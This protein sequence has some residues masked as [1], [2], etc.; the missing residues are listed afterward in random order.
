LP[1]LRCLISTYK[2]NIIMKKQ[3]LT[4]KALALL[5]AAAIFLSSCASTTLIQSVPSGAKVYIDGETVGTTPHPHTDKK[6]I[7][8]NTSIVLEKEGYEPFAT[9]ITRSEEP[10]LGAIIGGI[11]IWPIWL[12]ALDY[13][14]MRTYELR[15]AE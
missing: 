1:S 10:N 12:W 13:K 6:I 7:F 8:S 4:F 3:T 5:M 14:A 11:F 15:P 9:Y 2:I